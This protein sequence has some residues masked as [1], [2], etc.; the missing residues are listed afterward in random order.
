MNSGLDLI[1]ISDYDYKNGLEKL[2]EVEKF[3]GDKLISV[4]S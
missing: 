2:K 4:F 3:L 1:D